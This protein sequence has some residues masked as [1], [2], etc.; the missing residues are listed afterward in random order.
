[1]T[2]IHA[3]RLDDI[4]LLHARALERRKFV[5]AIERDDDF[6][7][8]ITDISNLPRLWR[9]IEI[10]KA[11][12]DRCRHMMVP[13]DGQA[14]ATL[15]T[16]PRNHHCTEQRRSGNGGAG[17]ARPSRNRLPQH[18]CG[19]GWPG[20]E[21]T[22]KGW[23]FA[24]TP[25]KLF[26]PRVPGRHNRGFVPCGLCLRILFLVVVALLVAFLVVLVFAKR[27]ALGVFYQ[28]SPREV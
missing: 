11:Q 25:Q 4:L 12:L 9:A 18:G 6:H 22:P 17:D 10:S 20:P 15:E 13:R 14:E 8:Y 24:L 26:L 7:R 5:E 28:G 27:F 19:A 21:L 3:D 2:Q 1:M 23:E 16:A